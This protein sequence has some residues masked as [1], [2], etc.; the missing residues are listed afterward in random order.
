[1]FKNDY[2]VRAHPHEEARNNWIIE[3]VGWSTYTIRS[4]TDPLFHLFVADDKSNHHHHDFDVRTHAHLEERNL[5][6]INAVPN[7]IHTYP[8]KF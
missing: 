4:E 8:L 6:Y 3:N 7:L 5:W 2:D 1:M